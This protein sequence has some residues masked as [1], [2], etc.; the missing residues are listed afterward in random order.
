MESCRNC[1]LAKIRADNK[2]G[3]ADVK[4][5]DELKLNFGL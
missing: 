2:D 5:C 3:K 1:K 4:V